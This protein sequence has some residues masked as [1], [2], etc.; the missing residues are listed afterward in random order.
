M[1][2]KEDDLVLCRVERIEGTTV[3]LDVQG[4]PGTMALSEVAAG[5]I[6]NIRDYVLPKKEVVC[7]I[8]K[9]VG[10]HLELSLRR[11]TA[12]EREIVLDRYKKEKAFVSI[13]KSVY[14]NAEKLIAKIKEEYDLGDFIDETKENP[15][16]LEK[17]I[18]KERTQKVFEMF[19]FKEEKEKSVGKK[20]VLKSFTEN[21]LT[22]IKKILEVE[23]KINYL[24]GG[25]FS[26]LVSA[27][28]F[29]EANHKLEKLLEQIEKKAK[30]KKVIFE[31]NKG[32]WK[33]KKDKKKEFF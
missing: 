26:I 7:R 15:K 3:F 32:K 20:F 28:D 24:G 4:I 25:A 11:V 29:K 1:R 5:R 21:G 2:H 31:L 16:I 10:N 8:L 13:L 17:F 27:N 33:N 23:A 19:F 12:K 14:S 9:V 18:G 6:R 22:E 30:E